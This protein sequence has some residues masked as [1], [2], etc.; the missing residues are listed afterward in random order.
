MSTERTDFFVSHAG[1][2]RAWAE[3]V[4]WHLAEAGYTVELD[5]WD[6]AAGENFIAKMSDALDRADR[7]VALFSAA[8]FDRSRYTAQEFTAAVQ[9]VPGSAEDRLVPLRV[10]DVPAKQVPGVLRP[11]LYRDLFGLDESA[12]RSVLLEAVAGP[13]RPDAAP[14]FPGRGAPGAVSRLGGSGPRLP[15][16]LPRVWNMPARNPGFAGRDGLLVRVREQLLSG[17]RAVVQAFQGMG[18]VGKTQIAAEY[19][20]QFAGNYDIGWWV[21]AEQPQ[22]IGEQVA[23]L[24]VELRAAK[25]DTEVSL[26]VRAALAELRGR[27]RWLLV[28]D[29]AEDPKDVAGLLPGGA[30]GHVLI[31]S[32]VSSWDVIAAAVPIDVFAPSESV[33]VLR[34]RLPDLSDSDA[35]RVADKLGNF[36]LA[37]TQAARYLDST[38]TGTDEYLGLLDTRAAEI[39]NEAPPPLYPLPLAAVVRQAVDRLAAENPA[40]AELVRVCAFL[41]PE[42]EPVPPAAWFAAAADQLPNALRARAAD[43]VAFHRSL[44]LISRRGL[45]RVDRGGLRLHRLTQAILRDQL[46]LQER[47]DTR[48]RASAVLTTN[49]PGDASIPSTWPAWARLLPHL[50]AADPATAPDPEIRGLACWANW[51]LLKRGD[52][53]GAHDLAEHLYQQWSKQSPDDFHSMWAASN[54]ALALRDMGRYADARRLDEDT[55]ARNRRLHGNDDPDTTLHSV[56]N[57]AADLRELGEVQA[58]RELDQDAFIRRRRIRGDDHPD[59]L[60]SANG[61]ALDLRQLGEVQAARD[62]DQ[63]TLVRRRQRLGHDHPDTLTS[64]SNLAADFRELGD[65]QAARVLDEDT[66]DRRR[67][68]LGDDHPDTLASASNLA[69]DLRALGEV[70]AARE[71]DEDTS[72]R[73]RRV[74]GDDTHP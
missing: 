30:A 62:L 13:R 51:Y 11:L 22:L 10:E 33:A 72:A 34:A 63:D 67:R 1:R 27:D 65:V 26:A 5:V 41:A 3:W 31:T 73:R 12:A 46:S 9:H 6:W 52:I 7:L 47:A 32:R 29:N 61:L 69:A 50:L 44:A 56:G 60:G 4:A 8:Y 54:L 25:P 70:Q 19:A 74:V 16:T 48:A 59:T 39:L 28:F 55:L 23:A 71:L 20:Y 57:L 38:G 14:V 24:A 45:A 18:G 36:P 66:L 21:D 58:A 64:A 42:P 35:H 17:D 43:P 37:V 49:Y 40:A 2:D 53:R 15:G 68:R